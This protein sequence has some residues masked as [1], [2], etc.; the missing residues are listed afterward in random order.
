MLELTPLRTPAIFWYGALAASW[1]KE[2]APSVTRDGT[3]ERLER[4]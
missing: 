4:S 3:A 1:K 2:I